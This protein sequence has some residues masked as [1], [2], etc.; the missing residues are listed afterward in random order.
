MELTRTAQTCTTTLALRNLVHPFKDGM[1]QNACPM[2]DV[3]SEITAQLQELQAYKAEA[4][5]FMAPT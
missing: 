5:I 4:E 2:S 3:F 1:L